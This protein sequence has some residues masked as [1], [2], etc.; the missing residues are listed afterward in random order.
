M[1]AA[2]CVITSCSLFVSPAVKAERAKAE[3]ERQIASVR[4][5]CEIHGTPMERKL[6]VSLDSYPFDV[7]GPFQKKRRLLFFNDGTTFSS[8][9]GYHAAEMT[10]VCPECSRASIR[11]RKRR[12][13]VE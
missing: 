5:S 13:I 3:Q 1:A 12:G 9:C 2:V 7:T 8:C 10:W 6:E 11:E 4:K